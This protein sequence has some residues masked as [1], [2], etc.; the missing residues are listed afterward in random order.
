M[1]IGIKYCVLFL[2]QPT[3][4]MAPKHT[5]VIPVARSRRGEPG[6]E[7]RYLPGRG[8]FV[9]VQGVVTYMSG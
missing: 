1:R 4:R 6:N 5:T 3:G 7:A 2:Q 9:E 8:V